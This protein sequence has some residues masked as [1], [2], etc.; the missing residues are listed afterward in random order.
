MRAVLPGLFE[1]VKELDVGGVRTSRRKVCMLS[2]TEY[3]MFEQRR[4]DTSNDQP[5]PQLP[6]NFHEHDGPEVR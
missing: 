3:V 1:R 5:S 2:G 4:N 6:E